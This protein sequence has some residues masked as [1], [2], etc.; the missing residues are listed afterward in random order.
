MKEKESFYAIQK[1]ITRISKL[2]NNGNLKIDVLSTDDYVNPD[3]FEK[4]CEYK[5]LIFLREL[6]KLSLSSNCNYSKILYLFEMNVG[7]LERFFDNENGV[8]VMSEDPKIRNNRLNLLSLIRNYSMK[9]AD[10]T[11]L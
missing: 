2:A 3:F 4:D 6:E 7:N 1:V 10:F 9:I 11:L 8:L 5:I